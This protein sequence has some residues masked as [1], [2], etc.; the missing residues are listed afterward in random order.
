MIIAFDETSSKLLPCNDWTMD[1][2]GAKQVA[3]V[4]LEDKRAITLG[5]AFSGPPCTLLKS[6][7]IYAGKTNMCHPDID[8]PDTCDVTHSESHWSTE[9]TVLRLIDNS[10]HPHMEECRRVLN[11]TPTQYGL[12]LW[13]VFK[14][15]TTQRVL[16]LL[17][18]RFIK[19]LFTPAGTTSLYAP[20]DHPEFNHNVKKMNEDKCTKWYA[21]QVTRCLDAGIDL[22]VDF[23]TT[24]MKPIHAQWTIES[25]NYLSRQ[26]TWM[27][28]AWK[29]TGIWPIFDATFVPNPELSLMYVPHQNCNNRR[30]CQPRPPI[31]LRIR[32]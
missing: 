32:L 12:T 22:D 15:H 9:T 28:N 17:E 26:T 27:E 13:D 31:R 10:F 21:E 18:A 6:Q 7:H 29:G 20:N 8:W 30:S 4:G 3:I 16:D 25:L 19:V 23:T 1:E 14:S 11:L 2:E 5:L 24:V